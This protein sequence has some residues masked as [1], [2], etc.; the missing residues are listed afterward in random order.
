MCRYQRYLEQSREQEVFPQICNRDSLLADAFHRAEGYKSLWS[1]YLALLLYEAHKLLEAA[2]QMFGNNLCMDIQAI[3]YYLERGHQKEEARI[4]RTA[5]RDI[6]R[7]VGA[8]HRM[9]T[10][11]RETFHKT[12]N[13]VVSL[14][15]GI[16]MLEFLLEKL[17]RSV[18][19]WIQNRL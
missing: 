6:W 5:V 18:P 1:D 7:A 15:E 14:W 9:G 2:K 11:I 16:E 17:E 13:G 4:L 3:A 19:K 8:E 10:G 12:T